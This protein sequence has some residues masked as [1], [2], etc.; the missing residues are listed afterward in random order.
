MM[1][2]SYYDQRYHEMTFPSEIWMIL[3]SCIDDD[4][5]VK[6]R[7]LSTVSKFM[8]RCLM[9][10]ITR[11]ESSVFYMYT[12]YMQIS[13]Y[14][15]WDLWDLF[16]S[17]LTNL[18]EIIVDSATAYY[19]QLLYRMPW[20]MLDNL[21]TLE[22]GLDIRAEL[23]LHWLTG[24]LTLKLDRCTVY[25]DNL[26]NCSKLKNLTL[27]G[28]SSISSSVFNY[29]FRSS[30][31]F[32]D[33]N[34]QHNGRLIEGLQVLRNLQTLRIR[35]TNDLPSYI[36][37]LELLTSLRELHLIDKRITI[38]EKTFSCLT[39]LRGLTFRHDRYIPSKEY[40]YSRPIDCISM[41]INLKILRLKSMQLTVRNL[42]DKPFNLDEV[43]RIIKKH[44]SYLDEVD[45]IINESNYVLS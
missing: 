2:H 20:Q 42:S 19:H 21:S 8:N 7:S 44:V 1:Q 24:L 16:T 29:A 13:E 28:C 6:I 40:S 30:L 38:N 14:K 32:L 34:C 45:G 11:I 12:S 43:D 36:I 3:I 22:V 37:H 27:V 10:S 31:T 4:L 33:I 23:F 41:L 39:N 17:K 9:K 26:K 15:D 18:E 25:Q 5:H 35:H